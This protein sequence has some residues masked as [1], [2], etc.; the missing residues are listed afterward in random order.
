MSQ[1][2]FFADNHERFDEQEWREFISNVGVELGDYDDI[3]DCLG[4]VDF[5]KRDEIRIFWNSMTPKTELLDFLKTDRDIT[6]VLAT[7]IIGAETGDNS[8]HSTTASIRKQNDTIVI[9]DHEITIKWDT[10]GK[11]S[12]RFYT[13][14][15]IY[16]DRITRRHGLITAERASGACGKE[17]RAAVLK[18]LEFE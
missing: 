6:H 5:P 4:K 8:N 11:Q 15:S 3:F 18:S 9:D 12:T 1:V 16:N 10:H 2:E 13:A 14:K 7:S 17:I